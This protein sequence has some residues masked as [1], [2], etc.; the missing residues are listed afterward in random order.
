MEIALVGNGPISRADVPLIDEHDFVVRFNKAKEFGLTGQRCDALVIRDFAD[1]FSPTSNPEAY[2]NAKELWLRF[3]PEEPVELP[4]RVIWPPPWLK[5]L[6]ASVTTR[7]AP[8]IS[9]GL[10]AA[11]Y[12]LEHFP[13]AAVT[14]FGFSHRGAPKHDWE[15]ERIVC[16]MLEEQ[17][18]LRRFA[19]EDGPWSNVVTRA[20]RLNHRFRRFRGRVSHHLF[21]GQ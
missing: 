13:G 7:E 16:E 19:A 15:A 21:P 18:R 5:E 12:A 11:G 17:G 20:R 6:F 3:H 14:L 1:A 9:S 10:V 4:Y 2:K 8:P